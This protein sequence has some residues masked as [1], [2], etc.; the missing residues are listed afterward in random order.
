MHLADIGA[1]VRVTPGDEIW[2]K[3]ESG[4]RYVDDRTPFLVQLA[5]R[6]DDEHVFYGMHGRVVDGPE[7]YR[8]LVCS[9]ITRIDGDDWRAQRASGA[10]F[11]V[12]PVP[13][14]RDHAYD[15]RH[16]QGTVIAG[17]PVIG[18]YGRVEV[19]DQDA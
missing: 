19:I 6:L 12:G 13:V 18:R 17:L 5:G 14:F 4:T 15:F 3:D 2:I 9:L 16:P 8:G 7:R 1:R 11:K 10:N